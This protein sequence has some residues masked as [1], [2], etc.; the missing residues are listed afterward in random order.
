[1]VTMYKLTADISA[2][3]QEMQPLIRQ[4]E[5]VQGEINKRVKETI[6]TQSKEDKNETNQ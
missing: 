5:A 6:S 4:L 2:R 3:Q 1:M